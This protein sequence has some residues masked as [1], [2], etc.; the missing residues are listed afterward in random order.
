[1][2]LAIIKS[3]FNEDVTGG[4]LKGAE[5]YLKSKDIPFTLFHAPG[6]FEIPLLAKKCAES[7]K[8]DGVI[9]LGC[10]IK[11]DRKSVV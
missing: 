9:C 4:L 10:V 6:A 3:S 8:F 7:K 1:M 11:G 5:N 2:K